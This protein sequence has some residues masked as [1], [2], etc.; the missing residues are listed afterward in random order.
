MMEKTETVKNAGIRA[1]LTEWLVV[2]V[3]SA[4]EMPPDAVDVRQNL[5]DYGLDSMQAVGLTGDLQSWLGVEI[6]P[7]AIWD[8]PTIESTS[9]FVSQLIASHQS[10]TDGTVSDGADTKRRA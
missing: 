8:H 2:H 9:E 7:T 10:A 3:A 1:A 5:E 4:L 6:P